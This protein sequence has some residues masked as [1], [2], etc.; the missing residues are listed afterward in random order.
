MDKNQEIIILDES[1]EEIKMAPESAEETRRLT[2]QDVINRSKKLTIWNSKA[3]TPLTAHT[4]LEPLMDKLGFSSNYIDCTGSK[5]RRAVTR[6]VV[7]KEY[8]REAKHPPMPPPAFLGRNMRLRGNIWMEYIFCGEGVYQGR[9]E[10]PP[11][12]KL[13]YPKFDGL[14]VSLY[15]DFLDAVN[16]YL[17]KRDHISNL[18]HIRYIFYKLCV[19]VCVF[20]SIYHE[21]RI[22]LF[23]NRY[24]LF[25]CIK[26]WSIYDLYYLDFTEKTLHRH[27]EDL[28]CAYKFPYDS[29]LIFV[30]QL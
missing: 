26:S 13:P 24:I 25:Y 16:F 20:N 22:V 5:L 8:W 28:A 17:K 1:E 10:S 18:F 29:M 6:V 4:D 21:V 23:T 3:F 11:R 19:I 7:C 12:P 30:M 2:A 27:L 14:H 9:M 15:T